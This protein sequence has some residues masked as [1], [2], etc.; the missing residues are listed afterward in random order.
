MLTHERKQQINSIEF[1]YRALYLY[2][3][4]LFSDTYNEDMPF[5]YGLIELNRYNLEDDGYLSLRSVKD[6]TEEEA[7]HVASISY[8]GKSHHTVE[9]GRH[10]AESLLE[11][12]AVFFNPY[13]WT[14]VIFYLSSIGIALPYYTATTGLITVE[15]FIEAGE[16][17][18]R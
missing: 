9:V 8:R 10:V 14:A 1:M 11:D 7:I 12:D 6:L 5:P 3:T 2:Q 13:L 4:V 18:I 17:Q 15:E 16:V